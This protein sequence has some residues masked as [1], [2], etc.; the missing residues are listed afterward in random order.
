[1]NE[2]ALWVARSKNPKQTLTEATR[3]LE[4]LLERVKR[5]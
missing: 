1:M 2:A 3:T 4:H 5:S